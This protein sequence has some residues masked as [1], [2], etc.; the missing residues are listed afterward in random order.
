MST[1]MKLDASIRLL[2]DELQESPTDEVSDRLME[3]L[4]SLDTDR[5]NKIERY[6]MAMDYLQKELHQAEQFIAMYEAIAKRCENGI[7]RI[8]TNLMQ[9]MTEAGES[10]VRLPSMRTVKFRSYG[11]GSVQLSDQVR[12]VD[13]DGKYLRT[14]TVTEINK[15]KIR[16]DIE[17]GVQIDWAYI[18]KPVVKLVVTPEKK[19]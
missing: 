3:Q 1:L 16:E 2:L 6:V 9:S 10:E 11:K 18:T 5:S 13:I 8:Q 7:D 4:Q 17:A 19:R 12:P 14:K 15:D